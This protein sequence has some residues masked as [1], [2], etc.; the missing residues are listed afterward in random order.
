METRKSS[1]RAGTPARQESIL[2]AALDC[3]SGLGIGATTVED[4]CRESGASIGSLYH[5]FGS[6]EGVAS[7]LFI[8]G[9]KRLNADLLRKLAR[10]KS[11]EAG[12]RVV[13]TQYCDWVTKHSELARYLLNSRDIAFSEAARS[14][15]K[16]IHRDHITAVFQWFAPFVAAGDMKRLPPDTYVP[17]ISGPIQD[18]TRHWL[19]GQTRESPSKVKHIFADAAW[20]AMRTGEP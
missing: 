10:C 14:E 16:Q 2:K 17:I 3:F 6:K 4:I 19:A 12:V 8:D 13:V 15:L 11:A 7:G 5:H 9:V 20:N 1:I 18:F